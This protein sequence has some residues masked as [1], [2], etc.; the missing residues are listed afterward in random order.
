MMNVTVCTAKNTRKTSLATNILNFILR[1]EF[2]SNSSTRRWYWAL[3]VVQCEKAKPSYKKERE[4]VLQ[5]SE[6]RHIN[7]IS[8]SYIVVAK[9]ANTLTERQWSRQDRWTNCWVPLHMQGEINSS[10]ARWRTGFRLQNTLPEQQYLQNLMRLEEG[11]RDSTGISHIISH[12][13][14]CISAVWKQLKNTR[15]A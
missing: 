7:Q 5:L 2:S 13:Q 4:R 10:S 1:H 8:A 12:H 14:F 11:E 6:A 15:L 9:S 3:H